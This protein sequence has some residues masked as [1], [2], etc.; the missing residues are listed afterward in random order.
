MSC[1]A[2]QFSTSKITLH[3]RQS[4]L[5]NSPARF[6]VGTC[7][8]R[9]GK[10]L[11]L[12]IKLAKT[13]C[14]FHPRSNV[15]YWWCAPTY[16]RA[17]KA[18]E[19]FERA[20]RAVI[21]RSARDDYS[22]TLLNGV[23]L[24]FVSLKE[25]GNRKGDGLDGV[26]FDEAARCPAAAWTELVAPALMDKKGWAVLISTPWG[27]NWFYREYMKGVAGS[28][29]NDPTYAAYRFPSSDNPYLD[30][31]EIEALRR[32]LPEDTFRQEVLAEFLVDGAGVFPGI[33]NLV[34][35]HEELIRG[36]GI[37]GCVHKPVRSY[38]GIDL[39]KHQDFSVIHEVGVYDGVRAQ[40]ITWER[41]T[42][43]DWK[44]QE[45]RII[46]AAQKN[47]AKV[48]IDSSGAGDRIYEELRDQGVDVFPVKFS[49]PSNRQQLYNNLKLAISKGVFS[50]PKC[51][52]TKVF[53][54]EHESFEYQLTDGGKLTMGPPDGEHDD[55]VAGAALVVHAMLRD[56]KNGDFSEF[57]AKN[58]IKIVNDLA[59]IPREVLNIQLDA[60]NGADPNSPFAGGFHS[61]F[62]GGQFFGGSDGDV[63]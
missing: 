37:L 18:F 17:V 54:D 8:R 34:P 5:V 11:G 57:E 2:I 58:Q 53:W 3:A 51:E 9:F 1:P 31:E 43:V 6:T 46:E 16:A 29:T 36:F 40:T 55:S 52:A 59:S 4:L 26:V 27:R 35:T 13:A 30:L 47:N 33:L 28:P 19:E 23:R 48:S 32:S 21:A 39:A 50:M 61:P 15:L 10:T 63:Y 49:S 24:E 25:W 41:F 7:G 45:K 14:K 60:I 56:S 20:M 22:I 38:I 44:V 12:L 42:Q 62:S